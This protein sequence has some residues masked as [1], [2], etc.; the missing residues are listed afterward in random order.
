[1]F[2]VVCNYAFLSSLMFHIIQYFAVLNLCFRI[3]VNLNLLA[4]V[5][6]LK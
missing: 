5:W 6:Q 2:G 1:M 3:D 4:G